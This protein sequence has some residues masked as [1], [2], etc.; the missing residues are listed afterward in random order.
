M[1]DVKKLRSFRC[2]WGHLVES[3]WYMELLS[4]RNGEPMHVRFH[5]HVALSWRVQKQSSPFAYIFFQALV[6]T[7]IDSGQNFDTYVKALKE[8]HVSSSLFSHLSNLKYIYLSVTGYYR[9]QMTHIYT[10]T[11]FM[12]FSSV[13][14]CIEHHLMCISHQIPSSHQCCLAF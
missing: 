6:N 8:E 14:R 4:K 2:M 9:K 1:S 5:Y 7:W 11:G 13:C 3:R 12:E 10:G